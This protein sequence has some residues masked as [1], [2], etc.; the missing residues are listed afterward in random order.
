MAPASE[1][2]PGAAQFFPNQAVV[3]VAEIPQSGD[4]WKQANFDLD[5]YLN[6]FGAQV[7]TQ[8]LVIF[9]HVNRD[10]TM[11]DY[12][13]NRP[14]VEVKSRNFRFELA[15]ASGIPYP[16]NGRPIGVF[17]R[18]ATRTFFY[19]LLL[20]NDPDYALVSSLLQRRMQPGFSPQRMRRVR[21]TVEDLR[22]DWP[23]A[24]FWTLPATF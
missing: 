13:R 18:V 24:P 1:G 21:M 3:L 16:S 12:E 8:R 9:R 6:F 14:S 7:G 10:G 15:A 5:N 11:A 20:P 23:N 4:R 17:V 22:R 2:H 19:R